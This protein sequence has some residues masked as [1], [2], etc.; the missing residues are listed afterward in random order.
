ML[1]TFPNKNLKKDRLY[2]SLQKKAER[3]DG[4]MAWHFVKEARRTVVTKQA[5][6]FNID[7]LWRFF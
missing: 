2:K 6:R 3:T 4:Y 1:P 7:T 5:K